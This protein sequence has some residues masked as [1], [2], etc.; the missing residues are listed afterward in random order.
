MERCRIR[1]AAEG[2]QRELTRL[3]V[4]AT[5]RAGYDDAFIERAMPALTISLPLISEGFVQLAE[6]P[7]GAI[8]GVV[9]VTSTALQGIALLHSLFV[10]PPFWRRGVGRMLFQAA[11]VRM[12]A[13]KCGALMIY[14]EPSAEG[15][16]RRM[17][18]LRIGEGPFVFSP[19]VTLPHFLYIGQRET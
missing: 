4:R 5:R 16:Y 11:V 19:D 10:D 12:R 9:V 1:G 8:A 17:G 14:A 7:S 15:F 18:A 6:H 3:C 13:L 2:E